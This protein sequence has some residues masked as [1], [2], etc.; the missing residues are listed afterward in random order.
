[1]FI[2]FSDISFDVKMLDAIYVAVYGCRT[3]RVNMVNNEKLFNRYSHM[4]L[5]G[6]NAGCCYISLCS[7]LCVWWIGVITT[8]I[9]RLFGQIRSAQASRCQGR[10]F[11]LRAGSFNT[12]TII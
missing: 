7:L 2:R 3:T 6:S 9:S 1:M 8:P 4:T 5:F 10:W 11:V 12:V